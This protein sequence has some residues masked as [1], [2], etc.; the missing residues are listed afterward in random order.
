MTL[1]QQHLSIQHDLCLGSM[2]MPS[3]KYHRWPTDNSHT[4]KLTQISNK[5]LKRVEGAELHPKN[6]HG[7]SET[8]IL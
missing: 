8:E 5:G 3:Y 4:I 6:Y 7:L 1:M 2:T